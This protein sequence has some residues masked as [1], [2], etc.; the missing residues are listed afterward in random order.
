MVSHVASAM[1]MQTPQF[2]QA[3]T[4]PLKVG[5]QIILSQ[6]GGLMLDTLYHS[7]LQAP[8]QIPQQIIINQPQGQVMQPATQS[9]VLPATSQAAPAPSTTNSIPRK[10][11]REFILFNHPSAAGCAK[12]MPVQQLEAML[13]VNPFLQQLE[14]LLSSPIRIPNRSLGPTSQGN[15]PPNTVF[16][17]K[18]IWSTEQGK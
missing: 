14:Q 11:L 15:P 5:Q 2:Q 13:D 18:G 10:E 9:I 8:G 1:S 4:S 16:S 17:V 7:H 6:V 12:S 3:V